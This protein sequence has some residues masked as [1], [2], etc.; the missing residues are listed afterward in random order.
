MKFLIILVLLPNILSLIF[1]LVMGFYLILGII[2]SI[3]SKIY[4]DTIELLFFW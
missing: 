3:N 1:V 2:K 4:T